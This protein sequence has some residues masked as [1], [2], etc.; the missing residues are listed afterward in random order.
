MKNVVNEV[1]G[2]IANKIAIDIG[3]EGYMYVSQIGL[4][5]D[6]YGANML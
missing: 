3:F 2:I 1:N 5:L 6:V 4:V